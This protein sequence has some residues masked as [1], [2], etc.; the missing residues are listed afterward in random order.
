MTTAPPESST[1]DHLTK[2]YILSLS[3]V[4]GLSISG[5]ALVQHQLIQQQKNMELVEM[6]S[7]HQIMNQKLSKLALAV[8]LAANRPDHQKRLAE[9]RNI[10]ET[11]EAPSKSLRGRMLVAVSAKN[12][13]H[14]DRMFT[15]ITPHFD[16]LLD[17]AKAILADKSADSDSSP[18]LQPPLKQARSIGRILAAEYAF[19]QDINRIK[20]E[21]SAVIKQ[22]IVEL[23]RLELML[24]AI[25]C[26]VL[27]IEGILVFRPAVR[28][29]QQTLKKLTVEQE[30]S[31]RLL[32]N[33]LPAAIS[34][35]LKQDSRAIA[36][37]FSKATVLFADIVGFTELSSHLP[38]QELVGLLNQIF[39]R[40]D[41]L[42]EKHGLEKIK[43]IGDAYMVVGG[44][45]NPRTDHAAAVAAMA[46]DMQSEIRAMNSEFSHPLTIRIGINSGP[47]IAGVIGIKKFIYD[48]WGDTVNIASRM[49]SHGQAGAIQV[50][51][52]TYQAL[53]VVPN[54]TYELV[55][56]GL[57]A[58]KGKGEMRTYWLQDRR[59]PLASG[60]PP[61]REQA[62]QQTNCAAKP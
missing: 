42:A 35:R 28:A 43:T 61:H 46:L 51:E 12:G 5:Q 33:I 49:E 11:W 26:T 24:L 38:P 4:A 18:A 22:G 44:L 40:F 50:S 7:D 27:L 36:D 32:L 15:T 13:T 47:V 52:A 6:V 3:V 30:K 8:Q 56:R 23:Q 54:A 39:S 37:G 34:N 2:L 25:T 57:I 16:T 20:Q 60:N 59:P 55:E 17:A 1:T 10:T 19:N 31:E 21:Y 14:L 29:L 48:L 45:P 62:T 53:Q 41:T 9:L 58:V